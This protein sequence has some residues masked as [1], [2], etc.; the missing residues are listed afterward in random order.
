MGQ[1][2]VENKM[3]VDLFGR[4]VNKA[5]RIEGLAEGGHIY[6]SYPVFDSVKSWLTESEYAACIYHGQYH[7]KGIEKPEDIY[8]VYA[9]DGIKPQKPANARRA[10]QRP[11]NQL[12]GAAALI[13]ALLV[14]FV[15][16][17]PAPSRTDSTNEAVSAETASAQTA[18]TGTQQQTPE[19]TE[20]P[21]TD[22]SD[23]PAKPSGEK[24]AVKIPEV[25]F[26]SLNALEPVLDLKTPLVLAQVEG[27]DNTKKSL[28]P[29]K[30]GRHVIHYIVSDIVY[31]FYEFDVEPVRIS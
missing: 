29:I 17:K 14:V 21:A 3:H 23:T 12:L 28:V 22:A 5:S 10:G 15:V 7:L 13:C 19:T 30:P 25:F 27:T 26:T 4:H 1:T 11:W 6:I 24:P 31:Y 2:V 9:A 20:T 18:D 8:E 16:F